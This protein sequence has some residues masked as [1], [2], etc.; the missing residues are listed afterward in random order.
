MHYRVVKQGKGV[1]AAPPAG[2]VGGISSV[3]SP[4][5]AFVFVQP[6]KFSH[7][8]GV[9]H[10]LEYSHVFAAG[11]YVSAFYADID[12]YDAFDH[13]LLFL[14]LGGGK[15]RGQRRNEIPPD[16]R[17]VHDIFVLARG[18]TRKVDYVEMLVKKLLGFFARSHVVV[19]NVQGVLVLVLGINAVPRKAA[20]QSVG[21]VVHAGY[22][23]NYSVARHAVAFFGEKAAY[24]AAR[25]YSDFA[26]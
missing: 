10:R 7:V 17:L 20:A 14:Q 26:F 5:V 9:T 6:V 1:S 22:G 11:K 21:A 16:K 19:K 8:L 25:R 24:G 4:C 15:L 18:N 12:V 2:S 23:L 13:K 3:R